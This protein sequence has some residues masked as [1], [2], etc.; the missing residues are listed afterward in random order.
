ME[1]AAKAKEAVNIPILAGGRMNEAD[2]AEKAVRDGKIDAVVLGRAALADPEY[3][4]KVLA[5]H[6]EKN[7]PCIACSGASL[8]LNEKEDLY[9]LW[10]DTIQK[11]VE[12]FLDRYDFSGKPA[13]KW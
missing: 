9:P 2:I 6:T 5:G 7:R 10:W 4:N 12:A 1:L 13:Q 3:P 8:L 11:P